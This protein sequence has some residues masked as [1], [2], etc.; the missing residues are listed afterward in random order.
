VRKS[1]GVNTYSGAH[2]HVTILRGKAT[3]YTCRCGNPAHEWAYDHACPAERVNRGMVFSLNPDR[4]LPMCRRCHRLF[5]K[6]V[7][8]HCPHGHPYEGDNLI[9]DAGKRKCR[10]C[11]YKRNRERDRRRKALA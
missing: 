6:S 3:A 4:Y 2:R 10:A 9:W 7:I 1:R 5:D 11:V 8:T